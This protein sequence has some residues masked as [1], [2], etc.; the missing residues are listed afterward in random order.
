MNMF[1][2]FKVCMLITKCGICNAAFH[3]KSSITRAFLERYEWGTE[4]RHRAQNGKEIEN[5]DVALA[6]YR[7]RRRCF[8]IDLTVESVGLAISLIERRSIPTPKQSLS[9]Q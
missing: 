4:F 3:S 2:Y 9:P 1:R 7:W 6:L 5:P 8:S